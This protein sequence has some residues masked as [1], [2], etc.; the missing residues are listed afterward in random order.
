M[1]ILYAGE[2]TNIDEEITDLKKH[3]EEI[4]DLKKHFVYETFEGI[5]DKFGRDFCDVIKVIKDD[6]VFTFFVNYRY[7]AI[8]DDVGNARR[9]ANRMTAYG[10]PLRALAKVPYWAFSYDE[11][12]DISKVAW[13]QNLI[14]KFVEKI[15][16][17]IGFKGVDFKYYN[18]HWGKTTRIDYRDK[19]QE[20][21]CKESD[22]NELKQKQKQII[23]PS[24]EIENKLDF[25]KT[26]GVFIVYNKQNNMLLTIRN[27]YMFLVEKKIVN[28]YI[29]LF[30]NKIVDILTQFDTNEVFNDYVKDSKGTIIDKYAHHYNKNYDVYRVR[31]TNTGF[32]SSSTIRSTNSEIV[33]KLKKSPITTENL[34]P[35]G[36]QQYQQPHQPEIKAEKTYNP[37]L[38]PPSS[39]P[40]NEQ[41]QHIPPTPPPIPP[42]RFQYK[43]TPSNPTHPPPIPLRPISSKPFNKGQSRGGRGSRSKSNKRKSNKRKCKKNRKTKRS[44]R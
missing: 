30:K 28:D 8:A 21:I 35:Q 14:S 41:Y 15:A 29:F 33:E 22:I 20:K 25:C 3:N 27:D 40:R 1:G 7:G 44:R 38:I 11:D 39:Q 5:K 24:E 2:K 23:N 10:G 12:P 6:Y 43:P 17:A 19:T 32:D 26:K 9:F 13:I 18:Y 4:T 31:F 16:H 34:Q 37:T 42:T 36:Q